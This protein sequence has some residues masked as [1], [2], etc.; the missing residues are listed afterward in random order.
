V[1]RINFQKSVIFAKKIIIHILPQN[2][3]IV[4]ILLSEAVFTSVISLL[5]WLSW[6]NKKLRVGRFLPFIGFLLLPVEQRNAIVV[7]EVDTMGRNA[8]PRILQVVHALGY[9]I[10]WQTILHDLMNKTR[11]EINSQQKLIFVYYTFLIKIYN[12][13]LSSDI[14]V[15]LHVH[16]FMTRYNSQYDWKC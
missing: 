10:L 11:L 1:P 16:T 8:R 5:N 9:M 15:Q 6:F 14:K 2:E 7:A 13:S 3:E 4:Q 12:L